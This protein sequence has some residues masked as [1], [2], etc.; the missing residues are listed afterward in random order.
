M[1]S[2]FY[3]SNV[4]LEYQKLRDRV[5]KLEKEKEMLMA[6]LGHREQNFCG[7]IL[8]F[9]ESLF[10]NTKYS[11]VLFKTPNVLVPGHRFVLDARG[12]VWNVYTEDGVEYIN[13]Q[14]YCQNVC[15]AFIL[16]TYRGILE[17]YEAQC[18]SDLMT[19]ARE[20]C[21]PSL[22]TQCE[23]AL[24][25]LV[26]RENCLSL[27]SSSHRLR[28]TRLLD[29]CFS[30]MSRVWPNF[31]VKEISTVS[32]PVLQSFLEKYSKFPVHSAIDLGRNDTV[33]SL[34]N[35]DHPKVFYFSCHLHGLYVQQL[36]FTR[37]FFI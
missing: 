2:D 21:L 1:A 13:I 7:N 31:S 36:L 30:F 24:I 25:P 15:E 26:T 9:V 22:F 28:A 6:E 16:W 18:L 17:E 12:G 29:H 8:A 20:F 5:E 32:A 10:L 23:I 27:Y 35:V 11:D 33:L 3:I 37:Y 19:L 34:L 14:G 4:K